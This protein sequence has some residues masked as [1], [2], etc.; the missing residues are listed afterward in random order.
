MIVDRRHLPVMALTLL[1]P[2]GAVLAILAIPP[3]GG[4]GDE[5]CPHCRQPAPRADAADAAIS[6]A[7]AKPR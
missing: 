7:E 3:G 2:V 4:R 6:A 1:L 5:L